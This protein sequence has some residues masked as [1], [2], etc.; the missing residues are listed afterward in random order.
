[1]CSKKD[2]FPLKIFFKEDWPF[3]IKIVTMYYREIYMEVKCMTIRRGKL[4]Y[5]VIKFLQYTWRCIIL[6]KGRLWYH[7]WGKI[8]FFYIELSVNVYVQLLHVMFQASVPLHL[9]PMPKMPSLLVYL[10]NSWASL[11]LQVSKTPMTIL[12]KIFPLS[13]FFY[14]QS[15]N[16]PYSLRTS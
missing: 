12:L 16:P 9:F 4:K 10:M 6:T 13:H 11:F 2:I 7:N 5:I 14:S 15:L 8:A 3:K 1:M